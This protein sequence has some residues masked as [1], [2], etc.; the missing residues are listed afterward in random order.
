[1]SHIISD[2]RDLEFCGEADGMSRALIKIKIDKPDLVIIDLS[3]ADGSGIDLI[4]R[5]KAFD[6]GIRVLVASMYDESLYA[7]RVLSAGA[8]G[9][10]SKE[11]PPETIIKAIHQ[12]LKGKIYLSE[13]LQE[14]MLNGLINA[15]GKTIGQPTIDRLSNRELTVFDLLGQGLSNSKIAKKLNLS[16]KTIE[17]HQANIK[18]KLCFD[19]A[20][21]LM[22]HATLLFIHEDRY[23]KLFE[24]MSQGVF[25]QRVD[26]S[27][28]DCNPALLEM[29][30]LTREQFLGENWSD[31]N[32]KV[33]NEDGSELPNEQL[34]SVQALST[35]ISVHG[36]VAGIFNHLTKKLVWLNINAIPLFRARDNEPYEVFVTLH[37]ITER[38]ELEG[39]L[40]YLSTHDPLTGLCNR[41][42]LEK[43]LTEELH[44]AA[45][46]HHSLSIYMLDVDHFKRINDTHGHRVGDVVLQQ[47]AKT[48]AQSI[49]EE[50]LVARY[51]GEEF[52]II[53]PETSLSKAEDFAKRLFNEVTELRISL[54]DGN[55][56]N[57]SISIGIA[58]YPDH[59]KSW[60]A[61]LE[62]A[63]KAM[64][65]AK[66]AGRHQIKSVEVCA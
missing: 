11:V 6:P 36:V 20:R 47:L 9:Y 37:D 5:I 10:V 59:A 46:Y 35:G 61:L 49:R 31:L 34:P 15:N 24:N 60:E 4:E 14:R 50:D 38:K 12:V 65:G 57:I 42:G 30:G 55:E 2:E 17:A 32:W 54:L 16:I 52:V 8:Q 18:R 63:D 66:K 26:G 25:Y 56:I 45:R 39:K 40:E 58:T 41:M 51:G 27:L 19:S 62:A 43:Q 21:D 13:N 44:R 48:L 29:L 7:E 22:R 28:V 53:L 64:Y 23:R 33:I 1:M 3:L